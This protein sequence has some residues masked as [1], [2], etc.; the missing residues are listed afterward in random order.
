[1]GSNGVC[2]FLIQDLNIP[3]NPQAMFA[4]PLAQTHSHHDY[5]HPCHHSPYDDSSHTTSAHHSFII[6]HHSL[7]LLFYDHNIMTLTILT[8]HTISYLSPTLPG[9]SL[10]S[11]SFYYSFLSCLCSFLL[12][13][14]HSLCNHSIFTYDVS[15]SELFSVIATLVYIV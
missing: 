14:P 2:L 10:D 7:I 15:P 11:H 13:P 9:L 5:N 8:T 1:M 6:L 12:S 3:R 4:F